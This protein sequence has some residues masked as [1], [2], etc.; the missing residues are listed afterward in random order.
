[1]KAIPT[2][3]LCLNCHGQA[4]K[5]DVVKLLDKYYP[6]DGARGFGEGDLRGAFTIIQ[7]M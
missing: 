6:G 1:M 5:P 3:K 7:P 4:I 2:G